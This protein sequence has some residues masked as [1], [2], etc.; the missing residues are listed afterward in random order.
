MDGVSYTGCSAACR[1]LRLV[2]DENL[3]DGTALLKIG[4]LATSTGNAGEQPV[5]NETDALPSLYQVW[6]ATCVSRD[7]NAMLTR[8]FEHPIGCEGG[9]LYTVYLIECVTPLHF[10]VGMT[11][12]LERRIEQHRRGGK[13][14]AW[15]TWIHGVK[16]YRVVAENLTKK[17]ALSVE[18]KTY[19]ILKKWNLYVRGAYN[20]RP[21]GRISKE[22]KKQYKGL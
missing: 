5:T 1:A 11:S 2:R 6:Q 3:M 10:Y 8:G 19:K 18:L 12:N 15:W 17:Q 7:V 4:R 20:C 14:G 21:S 9:S 22:H 13:D 16:N